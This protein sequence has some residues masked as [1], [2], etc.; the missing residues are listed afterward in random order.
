ML[1]VL[2]PFGY[3]LSYSSFSYDWSSGPPSSVAVCAPLELALR[4]GNKGGMDAH[5]VVQA[6]VSWPGMPGAPVLQLGAAQRV[7]VPRGGSVS[8]SL[9]I[10]PRQ[11]AVVSSLRFVC[12]YIFCHCLD[13][14]CRCGA[15]TVGE[16]LGGRVLTNVSAAASS[17]CCALC[18]EY[19]DACEGYTY[20][21]GRCLLYAERVQGSKTAGAVSADVAPELVLVPGALRVSVGPQSVRTAQ[22]LV[23]DVILTGSATTWDE[24]KRETGAGAV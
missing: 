15:E 17:A 16:V 24:C 4:V 6:Y 21:Q 23:A 9:S 12:L 5:E 11:L 1:L 7:F 3:G 10:S 20:L 2:Y 8:V 13:C 22:T 19:G 14:A 18:T